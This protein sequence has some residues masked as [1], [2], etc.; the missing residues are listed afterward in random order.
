LARRNEKKEAPNSHERLAWR[1]VIAVGYSEQR[2]NSLA[3]FPID[4]SRVNLPIPEDV[5]FSQFHPLERGLKILAA[6]FSVS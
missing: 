6:R 4:D 3:V 1:K 2:K 5:Q